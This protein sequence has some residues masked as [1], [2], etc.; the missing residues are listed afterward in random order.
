MHID[1][2]NLANLVDKITEHQTFFTPR[3]L[4]QRSNSFEKLMVFAMDIDMLNL[5]NLVGKVQVMVEY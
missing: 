1:K 2:L 3:K 4:Y 5:T